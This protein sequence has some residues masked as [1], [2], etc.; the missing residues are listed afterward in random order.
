[1]LEQHYVELE[2]LAN[3]QEEMPPLDTDLFIE[4]GAAPGAGFELDG[5]TVGSIEL[6]RG[7]GNTGPGA[8]GA[9]PG[10][11]EAAEQAKA[12]SELNQLLEISFSAHDASDLISK[13]LQPLIPCDCFAVYLKSGTSILPLFMDGR[14]AKGFSSRPIPIGE[15]LSGWVAE[16]GRPIVNGNPTV[17][18]NFLTASTTFTAN[19][20][21]LSVPLLNRGG[22]LLGVLT[23]YAS[24]PGAFSK[25]HLRILQAIHSSFS[26]ALENALRFPLAESAAGIDRSA[27]LLE[28]LPHP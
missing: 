24:Q 2:K 5:S 18:P 7:A 19:S 4:R 12:I 13:R 27:R 28:G 11:D 21:A 22:A 10:F 1:L 8:L 25:D 20:S 26:V 9:K 17:E 3:Q 23:I 16:N 15:G 14:L 6:G